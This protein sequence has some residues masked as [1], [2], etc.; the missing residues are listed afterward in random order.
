MPAEEPE[1]PEADELPAA[2]EPEEAEKAEEPK[3]PEPEP[4]AAE[5]PNAEVERP[6]TDTHSD[7]DLLDDEIVKATAGSHVRIGQSPFGI[8]F[9][10]LEEYEEDYER[11][12]EEF[13]R[14]RAQLDEEE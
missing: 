2:A 6:R 11:A 9:G 14:F 12:L 5:T 7:L 4:A 13:R 3:E 1:A 8:D 10:F